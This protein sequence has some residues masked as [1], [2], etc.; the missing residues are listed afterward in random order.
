MS[1]TLT[2]IVQER[3]LVTIPVQVRNELG[4]KVGDTV[5]FFK[6]PN[7]YYHIVTVKTV[8]KGIPRKISIPIN[9]TLP[10]EGD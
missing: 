9:R 2:S 10:V 8:P 3:G 1:K 4:I 5:E 6:A 7:S